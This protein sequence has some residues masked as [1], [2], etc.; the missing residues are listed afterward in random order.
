MA[1][2]ECLLNKRMTLAKEQLCVAGTLRHGQRTEICPV[3][4]RVDE[5]VNRLGSRDR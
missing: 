3:S 5:R 2:M 4:R 1:P